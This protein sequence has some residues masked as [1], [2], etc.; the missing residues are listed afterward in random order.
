MNTHAAIL[1]IVMAGKINM[2]VVT[3]TII[4]AINVTARF[5]GPFL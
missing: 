5:Q 2:Y 1:V 3:N 4:H